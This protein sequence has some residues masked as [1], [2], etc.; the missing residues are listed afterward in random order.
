[1]PGAEEQ[2]WLAL[3][4]DQLQGLVEKRNP[5]GRVPG[6]MVYRRHLHERAAGP[7]SLADS[8]KVCDRTPQKTQGVVESPL[9]PSER[10]PQ[11]QEDR[12][13]KNVPRAF[14]EA[15]KSGLKRLLCRRE[16]E[17]HP[18]GIADVA[19]GSRPKISNMLSSI[20]SCIQPVRKA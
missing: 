9:S 12:P 16:V 4:I 17:S 1:V 14:P 11:I 3:R 18:A 8:Q 6:L 10:G 7:V 20:A 5:G 13:L 19:P 2:A 15:G